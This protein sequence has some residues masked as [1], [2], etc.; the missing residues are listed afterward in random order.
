MASTPVSDRSV[1]QQV[2]NKLAG[3]G[4]GAPCRVTV[5]SRN[6]DVTL[7]GSVQ[8]AHQK[9]TAVQAAGSVAG[10]RRV[11]DRLIVKAVVKY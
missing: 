11:T 1:T 3:R 4:L 2:T 7:S 9:Q 10:V 5:E 6:G 8:H